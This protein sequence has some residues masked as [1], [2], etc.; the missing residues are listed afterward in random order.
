M[1]T[2]CFHLKV[3]PGDNFTKPPHTS[4]PMTCATYSQV[5]CCSVRR[6]ESVATAQG[7][8]RTVERMKKRRRSQSRALIL[9]R[10]AFRQPCFHGIKEVEPVVCIFI[11]TKHRSL[12]LSVRRSLHRKAN[13]EEIFAKF[14]SRC[15]VFVQ[16][17]SRIFL[18]PARTNTNNMHTHSKQE[19]HRDYRSRHLK[20]ACFYPVL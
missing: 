4:R 6:T 17:P 15:R 18:L 11:G 5:W 16:A 3:Q 8:S 1:T 9:Y 20:M 2:R 14:S 12:N 19:K 10:L 7:Q 13:A